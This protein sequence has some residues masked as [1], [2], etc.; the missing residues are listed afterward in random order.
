MK[1][2]L[3]AAAAA[4]ILIHPASAQR[5]NY[6]SMV[7]SHAAANGV[8][9]ELVH[10]VIVR[11]SRYNPRAVSKGNYGM[12]QIKLATARSLGYTGTAQGLLDPDTNLTYAV[13]YLAGAYQAAGG[14]H[15]RAVSYYAGGYYY[16]AK[17]QG[18]LPRQQVQ[19]QAEPSITLFDANAQ[20]LPARRHRHHRH[21]H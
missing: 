19:A 5:A 16:A 11:E 9:A 15:N 12:M 20:V 1:R 8:P 10:R 2:V 4:M 7:A 13:K 6:E 18:L 21:H 3:L 14:N 17:R